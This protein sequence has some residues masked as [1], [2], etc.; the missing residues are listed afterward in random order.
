MDIS[1]GQVQDNMVAGK[2]RLHWFATS[3]WTAIISRCF[4]EAS[5]DISAYP[6]LLELLTRLALELRNYGFKGQIDRKE[7]IFQSLESDWPE[8]FNIICGVRAF[9]QDDRQTDWNYTN[10]R[11]SVAPSPQPATSQS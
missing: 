4:V 10:G 2:Y 9:R 6:D 3:Q 1:D 8:I 5:K 11:F 7:R